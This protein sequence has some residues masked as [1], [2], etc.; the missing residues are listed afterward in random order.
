MFLNEESAW[1]NI[2]LSHGL[3][4]YSYSLVL[5][6]Q[7]DMGQNIFDRQQQPRSTYLIRDVS[8]WS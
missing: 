1:L 3:Y 5:D 8:N 2:S 6:L 7:P 4:S